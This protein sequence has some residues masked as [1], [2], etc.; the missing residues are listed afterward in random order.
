MI[1]VKAN[2]IPICNHYTLHTF[3]GGRSDSAV[4]LQTLPRSPVQ[5]VLFASIGRQGNGMPLSVV[6]A[7]ARLEIDPGRK[8]PGWRTCRR[9]ARLPRWMA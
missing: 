6:S 3:D 8:P 7:L 1:L 5:R 9:N 4:S 2:N